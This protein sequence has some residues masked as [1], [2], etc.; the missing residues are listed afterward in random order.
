MTHIRTEPA[1]NCPGCGAGPMVLRRPKPGDDWTPFWGCRDYPA[2]DC[3]RDDWLPGL[4][5]DPFLGSGTTLLVAKELGLRG[6][7]LDLSGAYLRDHAAVRGLG[8]TPAGALA[9]LPLFEGLGEV[10]EMREVGR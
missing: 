6:L 10:T 8:R 1:P 3:G 2:C 9:E 7:G 5:L 4:V